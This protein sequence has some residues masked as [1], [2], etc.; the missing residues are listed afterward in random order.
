[1]IL[2]NV[3]ENECTCLIVSAHFFVQMSNSDE[4]LTFDKAR[5]SNLKVRVKS[6]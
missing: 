1:M 5:L 6:L 3:A 4:F 2:E